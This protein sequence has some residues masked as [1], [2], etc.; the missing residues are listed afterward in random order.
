MEKLPLQEID[1]LQRERVFV[2]CIEE[3]EIFFTK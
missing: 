2:Y 1:K 3:I